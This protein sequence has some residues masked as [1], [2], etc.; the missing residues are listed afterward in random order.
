LEVVLRIAL[1]CIVCLLSA[2]LPAEQ[3]FDA[4]EWFGDALLD[5]SRDDHANSVR[6][7]L[8]LGGEP[9]PRFAEI[10]TSTGTRDYDLEADGLTL[11]PGAKATAALQFDMGVASGTFSVRVV[12]LAPGA[13]LAWRVNGNSNLL[14]EL[15]LNDDDA[16]LRLRV[17]GR[18]RYV[19]IPGALEGGSWP[20][21]AM[22]SVRVRAKSLT[23]TFG[24]LKVHAE[25]N[26]ADGAEVALAA[27]DATARVHDIRASAAL[28]GSWLRD[29]QSRQAARR[30]LA[31]LTNFATAGVL[32]GVVSTGF[33]GAEAALEDYSPEQRRERATGTPEALLAVANAL[34]D[35]A[36]A[37]HEAGVAL[38]LSGRA[39]DASTYLERALQLE[40]QAATQVALAE[41][42]RRT[43]EHGRARAL[44]ADLPELDEALRADMALVRARMLADDGDLAGAAR[45]LERATV[46]LPGHEQLEAF[47]ESARALTSAMQLRNAGIEAPFGLRLLTDVHAERLQPVLAQLAP[48]EAAI[49]SWLPGLPETLAGTI[50][51]YESPVTYLNAGLLVAGDHLDN[52]AGMFLPKGM[53]GGP[54]VLACRAFGQDELLR[55]LV[56]ELWHLALNSTGHAHKVPRWLDE[57]MAVYLSAGRV[58]DGELL[59]DRIPREV[60][61]VQGLHE[62]AVTPEVLARAVESNPVEFYQT[63]HVRANYA[64]AWAVVWYLGQSA[65]HADWLRRAVAADAE[66]L[67]TLTPKVATLAQHVAEALSDLQE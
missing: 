38:L 24:E 23:A 29:A 22:F 1:F 11:K 30:A 67:A 13:I 62:A 57:G 50:A 28:S 19:Q 56:H 41:A 45:L 58:K 55:T 32:A 39:L 65:E 36:L 42:A 34:P 8:P 26:F 66:A 47:L 54:T 7:A 52:V 59:F 21:D 64:A 16:V 15:L 49:R 63:G 3:E 53:Y 25:A 61:D 43:Y 2:H 46:A 51:V 12:E 33:A 44:L 37:Q 6:L 4:A 10:A 5:Y 60:A 35:S 17:A 31:R 18:Q 27:S 48:Y 40:T 9:L 20:E 14:A